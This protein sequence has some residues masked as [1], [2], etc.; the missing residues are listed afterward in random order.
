MRFYAIASARD[1]IWG[2]R[3]GRFYVSLAG[4]SRWPLFSERHGAVR[5]LSLGGGWRLRLRVT[6]Q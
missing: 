2:I 6:P 4:P 5:V 3:I 1:Q